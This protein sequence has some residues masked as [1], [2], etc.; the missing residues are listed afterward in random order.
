MR[1]GSPLLPE[2]GGEEQ[3]RGKG[4]VSVREEEGRLLH[5]APAG[6]GGGG[7]IGSRRKQ[8][9]NWWAGI[10]RGWVGPNNNN[11]NNNLS[12]L[13]NPVRSMC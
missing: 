8:G 11:N 10:Q 1:W 7:Q 9:D 5:P 3:G 6:G 13:N 4:D 12:G 2:G